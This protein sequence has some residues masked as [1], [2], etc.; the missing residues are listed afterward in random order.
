MAGPFVTWKA[1]PFVKKKHWFFC[2]EEE[3]WPLVTYEPVEF[4]KQPFKVQ[5]FRNITDQL[6]ESIEH[7]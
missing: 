6:E 4:E 2:N 7:S 1:G 5:D 3:N